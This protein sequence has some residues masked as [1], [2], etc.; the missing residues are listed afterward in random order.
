MHNQYQEKS[1]PKIC[2]T[3]VIFKP[4]PKANNRPMGEKSS[5]LVALFAY[6]KTS[7]LSS[8]NAKENGHR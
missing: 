8:A 5:N 2:S 6:Q 4:L 3:F 1:S 7:S